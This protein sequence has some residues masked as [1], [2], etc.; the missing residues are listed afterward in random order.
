VEATFVGDVRTTGA[1]L[2][3]SA[4]GAAF[5]RSSI[6]SLKFGLTASPKAGFVPRDGTDF[7]LIGRGLA[8]VRKGMSSSS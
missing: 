6:F 7:S 1:H 8:S 5:G 2:E 4:T 3:S